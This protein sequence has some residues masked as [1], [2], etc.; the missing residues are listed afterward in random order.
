MI[1]RGHTPLWRALNATAPLFEFRSDK[2]GTMNDDRIMEI[3]ID[4]GT[5]AA[6]GLTTS[7]VAIN[8]RGQLPATEDYTTGA[9]VTLSDYGAN[10][11]G[12]LIGPPPAKIYTGHALRY[13]GRI[14]AQQVTDAGDGPSQAKRWTTRIELGDWLALAT[15]IDAGAVASGDNPTPF[16]L[17]NSVITNAYIPLSGV[18]ALGSGWPRI[19]LEMFATVDTS[20]VWGKYAADLGVLVRTERESFQP[21]ALSVVNRTALAAAWRDLVPVPLMRR[22]CLAAATWDQPVSYPVAVKWNAQR[23]DRTPIGGTAYSGSFT[24]QFAVEDVDLGDVFDLYNILPTVMQARANRAAGGWRLQT[25]TVD[26]LALLT[27][28]VSADRLLA[29]QLLRLNVGDPLALSW[30]WP[31]GIAGVWFVSRMAERITPAAWTIS[32]DLH[33]H[34]E[35]CGVPSPDV[36]GNTWDTAHRRTTAWDSVSGPW[37]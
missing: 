33:P 17:Y 6:A 22:H 31:T 10:L 36:R 5:G 30:D 23:S 26:M 12:A 7:S 37:S 20:T 3:T 11:V 1:G 2:H 32:L 9:A 21:S 18:R 15:T 27:S 8:V 24:T 4:H 35:I 16:D 19:D 25:V 14:A 13:A 28:E 34:S 29:G